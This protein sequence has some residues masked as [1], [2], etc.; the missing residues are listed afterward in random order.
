MMALGVLLFLLVPN[1][2]AMVFARVLQGASG[3]GVGR[4]DV[5]G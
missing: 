2:T 1:Y 4:L 3:S 5:L